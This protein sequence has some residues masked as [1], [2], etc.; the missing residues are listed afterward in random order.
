MNKHALLNNNNGNHL[1][2]EI[3]I[4]DNGDSKITN[5]ILCPTLSTTYKYQIMKTNI[6]TKMSDI[7][8]FIVS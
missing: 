7:A 8:I 1:R 6:F 4:E 5:K 2:T 3:G